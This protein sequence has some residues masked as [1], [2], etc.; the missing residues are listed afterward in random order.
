MAESMVLQA[1][2]NAS[3]GPLAAKVDKLTL[4][5]SGLGQSLWE[6]T[7]QPDAP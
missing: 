1:V 7:M 4:R 5:L 3:L 6:A 2:K